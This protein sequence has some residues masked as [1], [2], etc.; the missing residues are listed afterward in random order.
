MYYF[1]VF[2]RAWQK[3][4]RRLAAVQ[5]DT[6]S[7]FGSGCF[8]RL[9][10]C[11]WARY[12]KQTTL[13]LLSIWYK[14]AFWRG[15]SGEIEMKIKTDNKNVT[16]KDLWLKPL[17]SFSAQNL[18]KNKKKKKISPQIGYCKTT[19]GTSVICVMIIVL[20][21]YCRCSG[22]NVCWRY[23]CYVMADIWVTIE[24][25]PSQTLY[26]GSMCYDHHLYQFRFGFTGAS[27]RAIQ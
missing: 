25:S 2:V 5:I 10:S 8:D 3:N 17:T 4:I 26:C 7:R 6:I 9:C 21:C 27:S 18:I 19:K 24:K 22:N 16:N 12:A 14:K 20:T 23:N 1:T 15:W 11:K 13:P